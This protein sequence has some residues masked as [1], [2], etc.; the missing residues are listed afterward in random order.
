MKY[1]ADGRT[2][3]QIIGNFVMQAAARGN[4]AE[5]AGHLYVFLAVVKVQKRKAG[6]GG[7]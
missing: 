2:A 3:L 6:N 7:R 4:F 5:M 1:N